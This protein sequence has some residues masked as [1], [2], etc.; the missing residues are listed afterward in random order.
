M[1]YFT[2]RRRYHDT[3]S[4]NVATTAAIIYIVLYLFIPPS[5]N[6]YPFSLLGDNLSL[7][8]T[9][10]LILIDMGLSN[11]TKIRT[12]KVNKRK[13]HAHKTKKP[14]RPKKSKKV[15]FKDYNTYHYYNPATYYDHGT[16]QHPIQP[17]M[18]QS[19]GGGDIGMGSSMGGMGYDG[20]VP[21][22]NPNGPNYMSKGMSDMTGMM[23]QVP[24]ID[25]RAQAGYDNEYDHNDG[26]DTVA[27]SET[28]SNISFS[29]EEY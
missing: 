5:Y 9:S 18:I 26:Y 23:G 1:I 20:G 16:V 24:M 12:T 15:G 25:N 13:T 28:S 3:E 7:A 2:L 27:V 17:P 6:K 10:L 19:G 11:N 22:Y 14:I 29:E 21:T 4:A 8:L